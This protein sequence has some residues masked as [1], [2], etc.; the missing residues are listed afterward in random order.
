MCRS[1]NYGQDSS[2][3]F[4]PVT[5]IKTRRDLGESSVPA[6]LD[7]SHND[8][9]NV[10]GERNFTVSLYSLRHAVNLTRFTHHALPGEQVSILSVV[11]KDMLRSVSNS[12]E[13]FNLQDDAAAAPVSEDALAAAIEEKE[14]CMLCLDEIEVGE[15]V[16]SMPCLHVFHDKPDCFPRY[17]RTMKTRFDQDIHCPLCK[18][19]LS[20]DVREL[21]DVNRWPYA[22]KRTSSRETHIQRGSSNLHKV[23]KLEVA[24]RQVALF[25]I[26]VTIVLEEI[27]GVKVMKPN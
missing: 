17:F 4:E 23:E 14:K 16:Y 2:R 1:S 21:G 22:A 27:S 20:Q 13:P 24:D 12:L 15:F 3:Q 26:Q 9:E 10:E 7:T 8:R 6:I 25:Y 5:T 18:Y 11:E 19:Q